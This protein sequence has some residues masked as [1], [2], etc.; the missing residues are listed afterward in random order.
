M[1]GSSETKDH[2]RIRR[3]VEREMITKFNAALPSMAATLR[4]DE[5]K[6]REAVMEVIQGDSKGR[7]AQKS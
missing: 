1:E 5:S 6:L 7:S 3:V 4:L 2:R